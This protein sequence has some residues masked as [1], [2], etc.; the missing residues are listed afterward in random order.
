MPVIADYAVA[1]YLRNSIYLTPLTLWGATA[2]M[3]WHKECPR[4]NYGQS[5]STAGFSEDALR[6]F[7]IVQSMPEDGSVP[8]RDRYRENGVVY[9]RLNMID[10]SI[11][12][13]EEGLVYAAYDTSLMNNMALA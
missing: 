6:E 8:L 1:A 4:E 13:W 9:I 5:L 7:K 3:A 12:V 11:L 2:D 10:E